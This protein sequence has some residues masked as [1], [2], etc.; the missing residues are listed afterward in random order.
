MK[1]EYP[2]RKIY[3]TEDGRLI[4]DSN[5]ESIM[6]DWERPIM[7]FQAKQISQ[8]GGDIMNIGYGMGFTDHEIER[9]NPTTHTIIEIH[10]T[11]QEK[12]MSIGWHKKQHV[13]LFFGDWRTFKTRLP[14]FDGVYFDT[15]DELMDEYIE[16][17]P[18]ILKPNGIATFFNNPKEDMDGDHLPDYILPKLKKYFDIEITQM[19]IPFIDSY[20]RQSGSDD[21][22]YWKHEWDIYYSPL[23]R[24]RK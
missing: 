8:N 20:N 16:F 11:V 22:Y 17:L 23:L 4:D 18:T 15:W 12:I 24:L 10:P 2:F 6:M 5:K 13:R 9:H 3:Y 1:Q 7:E 19:K 14:K 21:R